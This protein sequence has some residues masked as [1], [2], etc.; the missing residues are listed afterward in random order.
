MTGY[1][2]YKIFATMT[3]QTYC[4]FYTHQNKSKRHIHHEKMAT[5]LSWLGLDC[6]DKDIDYDG[7]HEP[8]R[9]LG[10]VHYFSTYLI[11]FMKIVEYRFP[12]NFEFEEG[13]KF[14]SYTNQMEMVLQ[15]EWRILYE[16]LLNWHAYCKEHDRHQG[17]KSSP[18]NINEVSVKNY[19]N[20]GQLRRALAAADKGNEAQDATAEEVLEMHYQRTRST[21]RGVHLRIAKFGSHAVCATSQLNGRADRGSRSSPCIH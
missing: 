4:N 3:P 13:W 16:E 6:I 9:Q 15:G 5:L 19:A 20:K 21:L 8:E 17:P 1:R 12:A 14:K 2:R 11:F 18:E 10:S 7:N